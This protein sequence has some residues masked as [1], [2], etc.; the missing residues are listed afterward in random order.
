VPRMKRWPI[1]F[2]LAAVAVAGAWAGA[3]IG[4][5]ILGALAAIAACNK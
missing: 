1:V 5:A 2:G 3:V 4:P